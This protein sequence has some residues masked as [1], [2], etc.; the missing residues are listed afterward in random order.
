ME[1]IG[2]GEEIQ[3]LMFIHAEAIFF[4]YYM[5]NMHKKGGELGQSQL[6]RNHLHTQHM[7]R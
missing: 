4:T 6:C 2:E 1:H 3:T 7:C 5:S